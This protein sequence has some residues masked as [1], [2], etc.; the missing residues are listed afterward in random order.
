MGWE[1]SYLVPWHSKYPEPSEDPEMAPPS[2]SMIYTIG[3][4]D[5]TIGGSVFCSPPRALGSC[6]HIPLE[7]P[8]KGN[9]G[10]S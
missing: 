4:L 10:F 8:F 7:E 9:L 2:G 3:A 1:G 5:S 6:I